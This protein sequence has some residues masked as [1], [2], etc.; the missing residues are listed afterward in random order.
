LI[1]DVKQGKKEE[2]GNGREV[3]GGVKCWTP[4]RRVVAVENEAQV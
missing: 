3:G 4:V 2:R 1:S